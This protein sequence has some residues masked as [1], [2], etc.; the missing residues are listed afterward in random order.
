M[1]LYASHWILTTLLV[2][3]L[4]GA[5]GCLLV[6]EE[7]AKEV[8]LTTTLVAF[9]LSLPLFW[10]FDGGTPDFQNYV[11]LPWIE[12][13][14]IRYEIG[15][16]GISLLMVLLTTFIMP[17]AVAGSFSYIRTRERAFYS[18]M[19]LLM[20]GMLGVFVALD[21]FLFF[22]FW[23]IMLVPMYFLIG[24]WGGG[25][26]VYSAIKFFLFTGA[27]SLLML[28]GIVALVAIG[29][30]QLG[31]V[32]FSYGDLLEVGIPATTQL[33]L[34][35][36]FGLA[37]AIKVP[38][39][40][41]HTWLPD[42]HVDAPTA[43]S[44]ILASILL[45][46]GVYGFLRFALPL[47]PEAA[48]N[49]V[50]LNAI[51]ALGVI[52]VIYGAWVAAVQPDAKKLVA[53]TSV[54]HLGF[55]VLGVF[56]LTVQGLQGGILQM[57]NHGIS[58]GALF[59]LVGMLYE[60]RHTRRIDDFGG[61][62]RVMPLFAFAF[63]VVALSSI[64]LPGTNGFVGEFLIL[65]GS[66]GPHPIATAI[67]A[68][69]VIFAACYML[70]MVQRILLGELKDEENEKLRD[71]GFRERAILAP[72]LALILIIGV[73][74]VP[75]LDRIST[76]VDALLERVEASAAVEPGRSDFAVPPVFAR[77]IDA[78]SDDGGLGRAGEGR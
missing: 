69:G 26:R 2:L 39:F 31:E 28:V 68:T 49:P 51:L 54:A 4:A 32:S 20:T 3:P 15:I 40:P 22:V 13:W 53:Y 1:D 58:T 12:A 74:P 48:T 34:F 9:A 25:R 41:F 43:G 52:G 18:V 66:F 77:P 11:A 76:S 27:G 50:V 70:P 46:M 23:E 7:R 35:A 30:R 36:A 17:L 57:V 16:D 19:L 64:G 60:R 8:A 47:F 10:T 6:R 55:V 65:V 75:F 67:A 44:V 24:I 29:A 63:V 14:G 21:L 33:W 37:F 62:A 59:L 78:A 42:A 61:I 56:S 73:Y 5:A 45:K 71:L 38:I 72:A